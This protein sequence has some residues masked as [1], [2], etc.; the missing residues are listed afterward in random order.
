MRHISSSAIVAVVIMSAQVLL[1]QTRIK[2]TT[3]G[4]LGDP[5]WQA[6]VRL[7]DGRTFVTEPQ[8]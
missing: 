7:A 3:P 5:A 6:F 8:A 1:A 2:P 4:S